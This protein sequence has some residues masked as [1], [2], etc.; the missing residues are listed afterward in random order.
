ME[1]SK[2]GETGSST[3]RSRVGRRL[4]AAAVGGSAALVAALM[5]L[6][7]VAAASVGVGTT[8]APY[9][10]F[11]VV[12]YNSWS[13]GGCGH[14]KVVKN[15]HFSLKTGTGGWVD[16]ASAKSCK[17]IFGS[18][19]QGY[20]SGEI[21]LEIPVHVSSGSHS[22]DL[23]WT[24]TV[25]S[26]ESI[27]LKG[28]C[29]S[30][31]APPSGYSYQYCSVYGDAYMY[32]YSYMYDTNGTFLGYGGFTSVVSNYTEV[33]NDTYCYNGNCSSYNYSTP[34]TSG[35]FAGSMMFDQVISP[36]VSFKATHHYVIIDY[37]Y[38]GASAG[39]YGYPKSG[40]VGSSAVAS[41]NAGTLGNGVSLNFITIT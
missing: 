32:A 17:A 10:G 1:G 14:A 4:A 20:A 3:Y 36:S 5:V 38:G 8:I 39:V 12:P 33:Y 41:L 21:E 30:V 19:S 9:K 6:T 28:S 27:T 37:I 7:P 18:S 23:N 15:A 16:T 31:T 26:M 34:M 25:N 24:V 29:P 11:G 2:T 40:Y 35:S 13:Q 22:I